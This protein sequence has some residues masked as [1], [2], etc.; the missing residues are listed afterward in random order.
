MRFIV[1]LLLLVFLA[2]CG[3]PAAEP[4]APPAAADATEEPAANPDTQDPDAYPAA[5][6]NAYPAAGYPGPDADVPVNEVPFEINEP[7]TAGDMQVSGSGPGLVPIRLVNIS[8]NGQVMAERVTEG[9]GQFT[10]E[11]VE[12][13]EAGD[14]IGLL[15]GN[16][17][18]PDIPPFIPDFYN[19]TEGAEEIEGIGIVLDR[20][21]VQE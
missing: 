13:L 10:L 9:D 1:V 14:E 2:A 15:L 4:T 11:L 7:L 16:P 17:G 18:T 3:A 6:A 19:R 20:A 8:N 21:V 5:D 12:P